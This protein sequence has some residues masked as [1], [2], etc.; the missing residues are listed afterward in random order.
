ME[1]V[2]RPW[3]ANSP[4]QLDKSWQEAL[5]QYDIEFPTCKTFFCVPPWKRDPRHKS[6]E[7]SWLLFDSEKNLTIF[8]SL[9]EGSV[10]YHPFTYRDVILVEEGEALLLAWICLRGNRGGERSR[11]R[12]EFHS[13]AL[14]KL[15]IYLNRALQTWGIVS[16]SMAETDDPMLSETERDRH[17]YRRLLEHHLGPN[18]SVESLIYQPRITCMR[19]LFR[20][21]QHT[22]TPQQMAVRTPFR[23]IL[24]ED[25]DGMR[26]LEYGTRVVSLAHTQWEMR[27]VDSDCLRWTPSGEHDGEK[28]EMHYPKRASQFA[29][30]GVDPLPR[31]SAVQ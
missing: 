13:C 9:P 28:I 7:R 14:P 18:E 1:S 20:K 6:E 27:A 16:G 24:V 10:T 31:E 22:V 4:E 17:F 2:E 26:N 29:R 21:H 30:G 5:R 19:G 15:R 8:E 12:I 11:V 23:W 25:T 3:M